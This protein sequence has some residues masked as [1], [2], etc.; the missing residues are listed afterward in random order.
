MPYRALCAWHCAEDRGKRENV[1]NRLW[2]SQILFDAFRTGRI[3]GA[4]A[5]KIHERHW[6]RP[7]TSLHSSKGKLTFPRC[8]IGLSTSLFAFFKMCA[9]FWRCICVT[10]LGRK[11]VLVLLGKLYE[12]PKFYKVQKGQVMSSRRDSQSP[13]GVGSI[14]L[15]SKIGVGTAVPGASRTRYWSLNSGQKTRL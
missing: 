7:R 3:H 5:G 14:S 1:E 6:I 9:T 10:K 4:G 15:V 12:F 8:C 13:R 2:G 11:H